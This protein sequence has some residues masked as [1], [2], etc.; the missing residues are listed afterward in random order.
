M[1]NESSTYYR[2]VP[3]LPYLLVAVLAGL[4]LGFPQVN[5]APF[6][7]TISAASN[8]I[9]AG[10]EVRIRLVFK[11]TT[12]EEIPYGRGPGI[13]IEPQGELFSEVEVRDAKGELMP[14]TKY[15]RVL[16]GKADTSANRAAPQKSGAAAATSDPPE[17]LPSI[18][19]SVIGYM[20]KPGEFREE[21]IVVS[22]LYEMSQ[23]G[24]YSISASRRATDPRSDVVAKSN[25][26]IITMTK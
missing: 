24:Q 13:G 19:M 7:I 14:E 21:D 3:S 8:V 20:L 2:K 26:L 17:P 11:N 23:P 16:R 12:S 5:Q 15:H 1:G 9:K 25:T 6:S 10:S 18:R 22:K 4:A